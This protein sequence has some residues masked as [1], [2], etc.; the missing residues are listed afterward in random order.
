MK[1]VVSVLGQ[2]RS[3]ILALVSSEVAKVN[4]NVLE[5]SQNIMQDTFVMI[6][7]IDIS[8]L[9]IDFKEFVDHMATVGEENQLKIRVMHKDIFNSMHRI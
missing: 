3:G 8:N 2:D 5:V 1:A 7:M 9:S 4:G 6:M